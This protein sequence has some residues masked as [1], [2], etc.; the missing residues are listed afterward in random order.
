MI[1]YPCHQ[2]GRWGKKSLIFFFPPKCISECGFDWGNDSHM[3]I[4]DQR[5]VLIRNTDMG[6]YQDRR[7]Y[8]YMCVC[9]CL[10]LSSRV[11][12]STNNRRKQ[13]WLYIELYVFPL[14]IYIQ[15][16]IVWTLYW[17]IFSLPTKVIA[18]LSHAVNTVGNYSWR[19]Q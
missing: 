6:C 5:L 9:V 3:L 11:F 14:Q 10:Q 7:L 15:I 1:N 18:N 8:V 13:I 16:C 2:M 12:R 17:D 19:N 4:D